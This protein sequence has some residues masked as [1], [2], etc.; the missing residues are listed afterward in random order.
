MVTLIIAGVTA[1]M[2]ILEIPISDVQSDALKLVLAF[3]FI[4]RAV[5][6]SSN[7]ASPVG[8]EG[9]DQPT[10]PPDQ[11]TKPPVE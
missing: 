1:A 10:K 8:T 3:Y 9:I 2:W 7:G 11:P 5:Q 6:G 4:T